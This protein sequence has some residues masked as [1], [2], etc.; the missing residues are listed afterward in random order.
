MDA[1]TPPTARSYLDFE[2]LSQL[3]GQARKDERGALKETAQQFEAMF[4]QMMMKSMREAVVKSD[5]VESSGKD[6]FE[7][8]FDR[9]VSVQLSKRNTMGLADVLVQTQSRPS[10]PAPS[11]AELLQSRDIGPPKGLPLHRAAATYLLQA[12]PAELS[13][14]KRPGAMPLVQSPVPLEVVKP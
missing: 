7:A 11:T 3:R 10:A 14:L 9:E 2:G 1:L 5:L 12:P 4:I 8:M 6:T 13:P